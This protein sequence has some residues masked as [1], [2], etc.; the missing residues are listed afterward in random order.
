MKTKIHTIVRNFLLGVHS[1]NQK[2]WAIFS[3]I[4]TLSGVWYSLILSFF[5]EKWHL[6]KSI[7]NH[8]ELSST[9][10]FFAILFFGW[11]FLYAVSQRYYEYNERN[12][13]VY[14]PSDGEKLLN[15]VNLSF[16]QTCNSK[17]MML[18]KSIKEQR[19][20][21]ENDIYKPCQQLE[22]L[23]KQLSECLSRLFTQK[24][25]NIR[26]NDISVRIFYNFP[27]EN[28]DIWKEADNNSSNSSLPI[29]KLL[30][31][32]TTFHYTLFGSKNSIFY[33]SK[34]EA[35][36]NEHYIPVEN[37]QYDS[38]GNL[39]GSIACY[40]ITENIYGTPIIRMMI[41]ISSYSKKF[42]KCKKED[43]YRANENIKSFVIDEFGRRISIELASVYKQLLTNKKN[44]CN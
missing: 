25:Y 12:S 18:L 16:S 43:E 42:L 23:S 35:K 37:D 10:L 44:I 29:E 26:P 22:L 11:T 21:G 41:C 39:M 13:G 40:K 17:K 19:D 6:V 8:R 5:G 3:F 30:E 4:H 36:K 1:I 28:P 14:E 31:H 32:G 15:V 7:N 9:G 38:H 33:N 20:N 34:E 24:D 2:G 27:L